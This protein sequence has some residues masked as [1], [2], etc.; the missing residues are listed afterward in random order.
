MEWKYLRTKI[1]GGKGIIPKWYEHIKTQ[2][3]VNTSHLQEFQNKRKH[4]YNL[5]QLE[6]QPDRL[7]SKGWTATLTNTNDIIYGKIARTKGK[8]KNATTNQNA[9]QSRYIIHYTENKQENER[10]QTLK[11]CPGCHMKDINIKDRRTK[12]LINHKEISDLPMEYITIQLTKGQPF[13]YE[14]ESRHYRIINPQLELTT[15]LHYRKQNNTYHDINNRNTNTRENNR[16]D[17]NSQSQSLIDHILLTT[18]SNKNQ[19]THIR[20]TLATQKEL[21]FYTDG[22]LNN[23][24]VM[25]QMRMGWLLTKPPIFPAPYFVADT[26]QYPS[27]TKAEL[28]TILTALIVVPR[29]SIVTI[30]TNSQEAIHLITNFN[31][32]SQAK[33]W[34]KT[35]YSPIL[36]TIKQ[37]IAQLQLNLNLIKVKAHTT[38]VNN[39]IVDNLV[40][41]NEHNWTGCEKLRLNREYINGILAIPMF[42]NKIIEEPIKKSIQT[43]H[44]AAAFQK[45]RTQN[46]TL[47]N[48]DDRKSQHINWH[49]TKDAIHPSS[50]YQE[51]NSFADTKQRAFKLKLQN[52][53]LST[54]DKLHKRKPRIYETPICPFCKQDK[55]TN[56]HVFICPALE[57][58]HS[59]HNTLKETIQ[60]TA[61]QIKKKGKK[62]TKYLSQ[63]RIQQILAQEKALSL[64]LTNANVTIDTHELNFLDTIQG[65]TSKSLMKKINSLIKSKAAIK[66]INRNIQS[67]IQTKLEN[68]WHHRIQKF[69]AWEHEHNITRK[70]K[71]KSNPKSPKKKTNGTRIEKNNN[72][73]SDNHKTYKQLYTSSRKHAINLYTKLTM[74]GKVLF[75]KYYYNF[76][77]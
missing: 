72:Y 33:T 13:E 67:F 7:K 49:L 42:K 23:K 32:T 44:Q 24:Y 74:Y 15:K 16:R 6:D 46:R 47:N 39:N 20:S 61:T 59:I 40:K 43:I 77:N 10:T 4:A 11:P 55:E 48:M 69:L 18:D 66:T 64:D 41:I 56:I 53:E 35:D 51:P 8:N 3:S 68:T 5:T 63:T 75:Y 30:K 65:Y 19:L 71:T 54:F 76:L 38:D 62:K 25:G 60:Y 73:K 70:Q 37:I 21:T 12:C 28:M 22:S 34:H 58:D 50:L 57:E 1:K 17:T 14:P 45:W 31:N 27:S 26:D 29:D 36:Q 9:R 2:I 52:H